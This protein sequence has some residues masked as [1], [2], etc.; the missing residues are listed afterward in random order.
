MDDQDGRTIARSNGLTLMGT[1]GVLDAAALRGLGDFQTLLSRLKSTNFRASRKL[2]EA[3]LVRH[4]TN[5]DL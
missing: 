3:L 1:L 5:R 2:V 4:S